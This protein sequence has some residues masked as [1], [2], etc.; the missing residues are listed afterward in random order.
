MPSDLIVLI[1]ILFAAFVLFGALAWFGIVVPFRRAS[2]K[3]MREPVRGTMLVTGMSLA[4]DED[5]VWQGG[6]ITGLV[7]I[8]GRTPFEHRQRAMILTDKF[9]KKGDVLPIVIDRADVRR[10]AVQWDEIDGN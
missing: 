2:V 3:R 10:M 6:T 4:S 5:S 7:T 9:P 8:P 1:I